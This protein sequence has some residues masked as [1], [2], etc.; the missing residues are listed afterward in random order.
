M[1]LIKA[2]KPWNCV[3]AAAAMAMDC[4]I[5]ELEKLIGHDGGEIVRDSPSPANRRG[6]HIQEI[7]DVAWQKGFSVTPI[8]AKPIGTIG[9]GK[10]S[11]IKMNEMRFQEYLDD[12][13]GILTGQARR[14]GHAVAWDGKMVY[15]PRGHIISFDDC[16]VA[17]SHFWIFDGIRITL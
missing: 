3:I 8:E 6:F 1:K 16:N 5:E 11:P 2:T 10:F 4:T 15:D 13:I 12:N 17:I 7:I 14:F 9:D